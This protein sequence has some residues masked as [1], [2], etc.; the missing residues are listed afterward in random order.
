VFTSERTAGPEPKA[1]SWPILIREREREKGNQTEE[2]KE[3]YR[4]LQSQKVVGG[5]N[6]KTLTQTSAC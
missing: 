2:K 1:I 6:M 3:G 4:E 5:V